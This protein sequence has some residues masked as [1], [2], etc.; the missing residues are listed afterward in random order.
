MKQRIKPD[1]FFE[2]NKR[3]DGLFKYFDDG[4]VDLSDLSV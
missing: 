2:E 1:R 4:S 3:V